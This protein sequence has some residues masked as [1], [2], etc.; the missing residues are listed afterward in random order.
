M[1]LLPHSSK[2][3]SPRLT[4]HLMHL[5]EGKNLTVVPTKKELENTMDNFTNIFFH[6]GVSSVCF[7]CFSSNEKQSEMTILNRRQEIVLSGD[8]SHLPYFFTPK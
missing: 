7:E 5:P 6:P 8:F 4:M 3:S 1:K 2:E